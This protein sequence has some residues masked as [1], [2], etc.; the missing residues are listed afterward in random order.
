[1]SKNITHMQAY[2]SEHDYHQKH[3][4]WP[5]LGF[6]RFCGHIPTTTDD[7]QNP[8]ETLVC[9]IRLQPFINHL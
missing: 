6:A 9:T 3:T 5:V 4:N 7:E 8:K 2:H 1:M